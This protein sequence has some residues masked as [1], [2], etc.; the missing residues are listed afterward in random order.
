MYIAYNIGIIG[1]TLALHSVWGVRAAAAG[2][3]VGSLLM[4]LT[5]LP[6]FVRLMPGRSGRRT[7][8]GGGRPFS[9]RR[10]WPRWS[11]SW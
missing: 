4:V 10:S 1:M 3:A 6:T 8:R 11:C 5:L 9:A 2:V 7:V